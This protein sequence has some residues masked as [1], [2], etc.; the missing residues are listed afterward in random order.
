MKLSLLALSGLA[1]VAAGALGTAQIERLDLAQMVAKTDNAVYGTISGKEVIRIDS[2]DDGPELYFTGLTID[3]VSLKDGQATS[4]EVW[5][6]GG[7]INETEGVHNSEAPS[8]DDQQVGNP[9]VAFYKWSYNMG[10]EFAGNALYAS[11][12]GLYRTFE[13]RSGTTI[14]QGR[15]EGYAIPTNI[16]LVD[17][18]NQIN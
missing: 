5:F 1:L 3:G 11:H 12:G 9:I 10:G 16:T 13:N 17:L 8:G 6:P 15:G 2:P 18:D 4:V 7:F 14:V